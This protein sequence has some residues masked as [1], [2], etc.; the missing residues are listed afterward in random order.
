MR[1]R[2]TDDR[3]QVCASRFTQASFRQAIPGTVY[4]ILLTAGLSWETLRIKYT[5][6]NGTYLSSQLSLYQA[7]NDRIIGES[8]RE[9]LG[10]NAAC[11]L[12]RKNF[13][14]LSCHKIY[15]AFIFW[16]CFDKPCFRTNV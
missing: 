2:T 8:F 14:R 6:P 3:A 4:L 12:L 15:L 9:C 13:H 1:K 10:G 5:V 7:S 11:G 16:I